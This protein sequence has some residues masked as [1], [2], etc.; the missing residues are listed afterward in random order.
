MK[1]KRLTMMCDG[2]VYTF[3][4]KHFRHAMFSDQSQVDFDF[5]ID[6][7]DLVQTAIFELEGLHSLMTGRAPCSHF[8]ECGYSPLAYDAFRYA[9]RKHRLW[10]SSH[11]VAAALLRDGW[12][13]RGRRLPP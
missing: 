1:V 6:S 5:F 8:N 13:P 3:N 12:R 10:L 9:W 4:R 11:L 2:V 7:E